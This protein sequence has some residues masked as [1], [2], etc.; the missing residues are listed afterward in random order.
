MAGP[1]VWNDAPETGS[2][3]EVAGIT[4][5]LVGLER[6]DHTWVS[7]SYA[8]NVP[9]TEK[10]ARREVRTVLQTEPCILKLAP[11]EPGDRCQW[12]LR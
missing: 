12:Y 1:Q 4:V 8:A 5:T 3:I 9:A 11:L 6:V 2:V 7:S 10:D